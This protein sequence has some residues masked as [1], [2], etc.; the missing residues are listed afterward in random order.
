[1]AVICLMK[2]PQCSGDLTSGGVRCCLTP[3]QSRLSPA[4]EPAALTNPLTFSLPHS[5]SFSLS[6]ALLHTHFLSH[7]LSD[8]CTH[9]RFSSL[10]S[11]LTHSLAQSPSVVIL[12]PY[13]H[14]PLWCVFSSYS[15]AVVSVPRAAL[16]RKASVL[17]QRGLTTVHT[18][19]GIMKERHQ[20]GK[21]GERGN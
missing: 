12:L 10:T 1:M 6:L 14:T 19:S 9:T 13:G 20:R 3:M 15:E 18:E 7:S 16:A 8:A 5:P 17:F 11:P 4:T 21:Q 2:I